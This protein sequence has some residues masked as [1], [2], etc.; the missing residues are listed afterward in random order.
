MTQ[1]AVPK[2]L[3]KDQAETSVKEIYDG[4]HTSIGKMPNIFAVMAHFPAALKRFVPFYNAV[5]TRGSVPHK[6]KELAYLKTASINACQYW[7]RAHIAS[8]KQAGVTEQQIEDLRFYQNSA[9]YDDK[10][11]ATVRF[12]DLVTR[13]AAA[14]DESVLNW[15]GTHYSDSEIVELVMVVA[16]ANLVNRFNDTLQVQPDLG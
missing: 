2:P 11:R 13:G 8:A 7:L 16:L 14:I 3:L 6:L 12:A 10:E 15:L 4:M 5:M 9:A 1:M